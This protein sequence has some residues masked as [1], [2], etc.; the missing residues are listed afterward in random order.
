MDEFQVR[1]S[2]RIKSLR[3]ASGDVNPARQLS[4]PYTGGMSFTA[5]GGAAHGLQYYHHVPDC[6]LEFCFGGLPPPADTDC[7]RVCSA[8]VKPLVAR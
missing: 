1:P 2:V 4:D 6:W 8:S 3:E 5:P 7:R